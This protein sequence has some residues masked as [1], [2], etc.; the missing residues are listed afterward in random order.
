MLPVSILLIAN[1]VIKST[2]SIQSGTT[3]T[4]LEKHAVTNAGG[5][6]PAESS[7]IASSA[8]GYSSRGSCEDTGPLWHRPEFQS[9]FGSFAGRQKGRGKRSSFHMFHASVVI[10]YSTP[11][12]PRRSNGSKHV[13]FHDNSEFDRREEKTF[14]CKIGPALRLATNKNRFGRRKSTLSCGGFLVYL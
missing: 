8:K 1:S 6:E 9:S 13:C 14:V 2:R 3:I 11:R 5:V 12:R 4:K 7:T 10:F